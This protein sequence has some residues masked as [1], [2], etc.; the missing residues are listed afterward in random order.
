VRIKLID[1]FAKAIMERL[2]TINELCNILQVSKATVYRWV[3]SDFIPYFK[4]GG[5]VRFNERAVRQWLSR[6]CYSGSTRL[7][8]EAGD[9]LRE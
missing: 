1:M 4:I 8:A 9:I 6:R 7:K 3:H 2:L 5:V